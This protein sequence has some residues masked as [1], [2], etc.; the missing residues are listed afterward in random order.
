V[1]I[2]YLRVTHFALVAIECRDNFDIAAA[3]AAD[4]RVHD[5]FEGT[6]T[7]A[8]VFYA[9]RHRAGTIADAGNRYFAR[10]VR[11]LTN[12]RRNSG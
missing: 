11:R 10:P 3:V 1:K 12:P 6:L 5:A 4:R 7:T 2:A 8:V 9:L